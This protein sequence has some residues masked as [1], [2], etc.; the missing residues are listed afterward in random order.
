[1]KGNLN[2]YALIISGGS[3]GAEQPKNVRSV[4]EDRTEL[5]YDAVQDEIKW[6]WWP[7]RSIMAEGDKQERSVICFRK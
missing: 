4:I 7:G 1:M 5:P 3:H 6:I 2:P